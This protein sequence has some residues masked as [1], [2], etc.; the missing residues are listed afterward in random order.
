MGIFDDN[1]GMME[2]P[3]SDIDYITH[4]AYA[5]LSDIKVFDNTM[6]NTYRTCPRLFYWSILRGFE[7]RKKSAALAFGGAWHEFLE[8]YLMGEGLED[9]LQKAITFFLA[10]DVSDLKRNITT[11]TTL[12][13]LYNERFTMLEWEVLGTE[14][15]G[16]VPIA[17]FLY[18]AKIDAVVK[19]NEGVKGVEHKTSSMMK[20][21]YF[22]MFRMSS[23]CRGYYFVLK[24]QMHEVKGLVLNVAH[25]VKKPD[26]YREHLR[27]STAQIEDW[28][29]TTINTRAAMLQS[30]ESGIWQQN[31][32]SCCTMYGN[33]PMM[34][35]CLDP[36]PYTEVIPNHSE[37]RPRKWEPFHDT[38]K[39]SKGE[40]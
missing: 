22:D 8:H 15:L 12:A 32:N 35:S 3:D 19:T 13:N 38:I 29:L 25:I 20:A 4:N 23:Q 6:M 28:L 11:L 33:C 36:R 2:L 27:W 37:F 9:S 34:D 18:G 7:P 24:N 39:E 30:Q 40:K 5:N 17:D 1:E 26:F 14:V 10:E 31:A 21:R 16:I